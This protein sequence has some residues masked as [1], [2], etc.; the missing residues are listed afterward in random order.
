MLVRVHA[1]SV[2]QTGLRPPAG[3]THNL[4][5]FGMTARPPLHLETVAHFSST[6]R[7]GPVGFGRAPESPGSSMTSATLD[8]CVAATP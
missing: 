8:A 5:S 7:I 6:R 1:A 2:N 3:V 4:W